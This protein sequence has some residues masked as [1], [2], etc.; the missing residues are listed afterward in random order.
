M[1]T[2]IVERT[3]VP[4]SPSR[5]EVELLADIVRSSPGD[6][7]GVCARKT[8][9]APAGVSRAWVPEMIRAACPLAHFSLRMGTSIAAHLC[10][11]AR[12]CTGF[13]SMGGPVLTKIGQE[14]N[15]PQHVAQAHHC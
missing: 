14:S 11:R 10:R 13:A 9:A 8:A 7:G 4:V 1:T 2:R 12:I 5:A 15:S 3:I 6:A